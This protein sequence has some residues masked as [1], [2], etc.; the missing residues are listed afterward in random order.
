MLA[1]WVENYIELLMLE[2]YPNSSSIS[3]KLVS[4]EAGVNSFK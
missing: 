2:T 4:I 3:G 1:A